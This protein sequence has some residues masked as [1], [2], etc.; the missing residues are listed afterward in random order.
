MS[1][2]FKAG[3][4]CLDFIN[5]LDN[6][7]VPERLKELLGSYADLT[8]WAAQAGVISPKLRASMVQQAKLHPEKADAVLRQAIDF[9]ET[10]YRIVESRLAK[11]DLAE[12][13][14]RAFNRVHSEAFS[15]LE[16]RATRQGFGLDWPEDHA[17]LEAMLWPIARS[18]GRLFTS[19]ELRRVRECGSK[20]CRWLFVD[21]SKN[22]SRRWCDMK[23]CG[24]RT[25]AQKFYRRKKAHIKPHQPHSHQPH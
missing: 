18:A 9:R 1:F 10:L 12:A 16:L 25:K 11:R 5:T 8:Q 20:T 13:D 2:E 3:E 15:H 22:G 7:P 23:V 6:R 14:R 19:H 21:R 17:N 4:L 24:N